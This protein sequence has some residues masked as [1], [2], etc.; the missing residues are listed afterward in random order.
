MVENEFFTVLS[1]CRTGEGLADI[2]DLMK[3]FQ[4]S[5][6]GELAKRRADQH[7]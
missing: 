1:S 7:R 4:S 6:E 2:W 3:E 5:W